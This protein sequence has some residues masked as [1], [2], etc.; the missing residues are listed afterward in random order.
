MPYELCVKNRKQQILLFDV[1]EMDTIAS[2]KKKIQDKTGT[3]VADQQPLYFN[4][5][6][7]S[8]DNASLL[9]YDIVPDDCPG[10]PIVALGGTEWCPFTVRI[11]LP[12]G[13][14]LKEMVTNDST[15]GQLKGRLTAAVGIPYLAMKLFHQSAEIKERS[16][17]GECGV[18]PDSTIRLETTMPL[19]QGP[20]A[21]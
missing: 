6:E 2:L 5:K 3:S 13:R 21:W 7:L 17:L 20:E 18:L 9:E 4:A 11:E 10:G 15:A 8:D 1:E 14:T 16:K 19:Y 12:N